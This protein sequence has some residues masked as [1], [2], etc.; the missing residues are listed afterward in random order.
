VISNVPGPREYLYMNGA[1]M[2]VFYPISMI[3]DGQALNIT[4][5]SYA[6]NY[7]ACFTACRDSVAAAENLVRAGQHHA[8]VWFARSRL[9][10]QQTLAAKTAG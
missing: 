2:E 4:F 9:A 5:L 6:G 8:R 7:A 10:G 3:F 1:R